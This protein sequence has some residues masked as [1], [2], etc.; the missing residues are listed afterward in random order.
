M[1]KPNF[2]KDEFK[3]DVRDLIEQFKGSELHNFFEKLES[4]EIIVSFKP[5]QVSLI[6]KTFNGTVKELLEERDEKRE[7]EK[8][9]KEL[10]S[11]D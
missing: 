6:P 3:A 9:A 10:Q 8:V 5:Q 1:L 4:N 2:G 7:L 11:G